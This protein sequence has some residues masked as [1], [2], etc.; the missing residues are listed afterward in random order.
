M[1]SQIFFFFFFFFFLGGGGG[2]EDQGFPKSRK[3]YNGRGKE[4]LSKEEETMA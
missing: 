2:G 4:V 3:G 1:A